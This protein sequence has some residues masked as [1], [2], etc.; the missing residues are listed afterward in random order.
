MNKNDRMK[1][2][3]GN[4]RNISLLV[5]PEKRDIKTSGK[6]GKEY[7]FVLSHS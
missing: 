1:K 7:A 3:L 4:A 2:H 6:M 5:G